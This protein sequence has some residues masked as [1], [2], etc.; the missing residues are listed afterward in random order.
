MHI[1]NRVPWMVCGSMTVMLAACGE[2]LLRDD[3]PNVPPT[4]ARPLATER[5]TD[6]LTQ[7]LS[8]TV[9]VLFMVDNTKSMVDEAQFLQANFPSFKQWFLDSGLDY[10]I[11]IVNADMSSPASRGKLQRS[12][13]G[14]LWIDGL[15]DD[16]SA[17]FET[18]QVLD[19]EG[20]EPTRGT[21]SILAS[22][23]SRV[24]ADFNDGFFRDDAS[25]HVVAISD[26]R[27]F[28]ESAGNLPQDNF[29]DWFDGLRRT[30]EERSFSAIE[31]PS[32]PAYRGRDYR[33]IARKVGGVLWDIRAADWGPALDE[34]GVR[35]TGRK[36]EY[37]LSRLPVEDT[38][39]VVVNQPDSK[40]I[41]V[42]EP[43]RAFLVDGAPVD[44]DGGPAEPGSWYYTETRNSIRFVEFVPATEAQ[45]VITYDARSSSVNPI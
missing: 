19:T 41:I 25:I 9:D 33:T 17:Q 15:D 6:T 30:S 13:S 39:E 8:P 7:V 11:G 12:A 5:V 28:S 21:E 45:I 40:G 14:K 3:L 31:D 2:P 16:T 20:A 44:A 36:T 38:V 10:H 4:E 35:A 26:E 32:L 29:I 22:M 24:A 1:A 43:E 27:D 23:E 42:L 34:L 18:N 37:F